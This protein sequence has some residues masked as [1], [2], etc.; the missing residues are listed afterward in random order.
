M[1]PHAFELNP[2]NYPFSVD[3]ATRFADL[4]TLRHVNNVA[5]AE[6][7]EESRV[8]FGMFS[9]DRTFGEMPALG[10]LVNVS[11]LINYIGAMAL[12]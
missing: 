9:R 6:L 1:K 7:F 5:I 10:R 4:D 3:L 12:T 2:D 8:R 11:V